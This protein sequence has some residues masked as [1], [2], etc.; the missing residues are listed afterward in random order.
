[1]NCTRAGAKNILLT[2]LQLL[3][4]HTSPVLYGQ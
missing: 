4:W 1:M 2:Y 3:R